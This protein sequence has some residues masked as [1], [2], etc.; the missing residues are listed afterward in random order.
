MIPTR[1]ARS[2]IVGVCVTLS[3]ALAAPAALAMPNVVVQPTVH[4]GGFNGHLK[5]E[6]YPEG[7]YITVYGILWSTC[8]SQSKLLLSWTHPWPWRTTDPAGV[9]TAN[10]KSV[11]INFTPFPWGT[12]GYI[13]VQVCNNYGGSW[14]CGAP[15]NV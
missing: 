2:L 12:P 8:A 4:C 11:G 15:R 9:T 10:H 13:Y 1:K 7:N 14:H 3:A 6:G 5:W